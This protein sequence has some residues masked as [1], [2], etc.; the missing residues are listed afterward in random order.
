M[1][2]EL[3]DRQ[4]ILDDFRAVM[5]QLPNRQVPQDQWT[6]PVKTYEDWV[7]IAPKIREGIQRCMVVIQ[8]VWN[9]QDNSRAWCEL[10]VGKLKARLEA[11]EKK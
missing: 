11:L 1:P 8:Q 2:I 5:H 10:Q 6:N 3:K 4:Q 9:E 7:K